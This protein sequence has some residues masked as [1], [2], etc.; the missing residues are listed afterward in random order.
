MLYNIIKY[1]LSNKSIIL[2]FTGLIVGFGIYALLNISIGAVPDVTNNQVQVITTSRDLS[3]EEVERY[4]TYPVELE[5][6]NLPGVQEIRSISKFGLSVVTIVFED[7][8]GTYLPRQLIGE[9]LKLIKEKIPEGFGTP[10]M[11]PI[12][13]G[14]GEIYQY[15]LDVR[16]GYED[17]YSVSDL[18]SIQDWIVRRQLSGIPGVVEINTWGGDLKTYEVAVNPQQLRNYK[19]SLSQVYE[20]LQ[21]N[22]GVV[23]GGYIEK[24]HEAFF[25]RADGLTKSIQDIENIVVAHKGNTPLYIN[26][27]G[28]VTFGKASRFGA[29]TGNGEGEKVL[30]QVMMLKG[31]N[32]KKVI[33][34]VKARV[35]KIQPSLPEGVYVNPFLERSD[36]INRTTTTIAENLILG[37][38]IV[39]IVVVFLLG[40]IRSGLVVASVIPLTLLFALSMMYLFGI[41]ANLMSLGAI[42]FGIIIDGAVIIVEYIAFQIT[43]NA[44][45]INALPLK[46][47]RGFIN[48]LTGE[49]AYKMMNSAIFGQVIIII[50]FIPILALTGVEGKMF[51]PMALTF[52]FALIGAMILCFTYVP[53]MASL[54]IRPNKN[55]RPNFSQRFITFLQGLYRLILLGALKLRAMVLT[56]AILMLIG[57]FWLLTLLGGEFV[58]TL[59]EGDFV[60]QPVLKTGMSLSE[61]VEMTTRIENILKR[62]PEVKQVVTRIGAAE[63][64]TDPMSME[65]SDIIITLQ[66]KRSWTIAGSKDELADEFKRALL[67]EIPGIEIEFTQ[68]IEMRF[69]EL[70]SGARSDLA[71]RLYGDDLDILY[72]KANEIESL[73]N[74]VPGAADISVEKIDGLPQMS[75]VYDRQKIAKYGVNVSQLNDIVAMGFAGKSAGLIF[76]GESS[77]DIVLRYDEPYRQSIEHLR[78]ALVDL[79]SG[80]QIALQEFATIDLRSGPAKISR[81]NTKR[82]VVVGVNVRGRDLKSVVDEIRVLIKDNITI[83]SGY[84]FHYGGQFEN[85]QKAQHRLMIVVP[86]AL[87]LIFIMLLFAFGSLRETLIIYSAIPLSAIGGILT[88]YLRGMPFSISAGVGFIALFG[89]AVLN[90]IVLIEH[91][92]EL[93]TEDMK[94]QT[95]TIVNGALDRLRPVL[96]TAMAAALGF[97]PMAISTSAGAEVQRP[98]ATVVIGGLISAT[99]LTLI[100]LP[101]LYSIFGQH[102]RKI[103]RPKTGTIGLILLIGSYGVLSGQQVLTV[104]EA[105]QI[106]IDRNT[107]TALAELD[108]ESATILVEAQ[109]KINPT[110]FY[111]G[112]DRNNTTDNGNAL[113][114]L[115]LSHSFKMPAIHNASKLLQE[116]KVNELSSEYDL[117]RYHLQGHIKL[118]YDKIQYLQAVK[119][120]YLQVD[121]L[122]QEYLVIVERKLKAGESSIIEKMT[123]SQK[124]NHT[125]LNAKNADFKIKKYYDQLKQALLSEEDIIIPNTEYQLLF[126][127]IDST[128]THPLI[129]LKKSTMSVQQRKNAVIQ[130]Q[131]SP[132]IKLSVFNGMNSFNQFELYP[133]IQVGISMPI[134]NKAFQLENKSAQIQDDISLQRIQSTTQHLNLL[135]SGYEEQL[136]QIKDQIEV[137]NSTIEPN[138]QELLETALRSLSAKEMNYLE[139]LLILDS[140]VQSKIQKWNLIHEY[141]QVQILSEYL[142]D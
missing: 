69:N 6:S 25:I 12:S 8:M 90:G 75:I 133:G 29:I 47:R 49:G 131:A 7:R 46:A 40:N 41:D 24:N 130:K 20:A 73:I 53:V 68:P 136:R 77:Y 142:I 37:F 103:T 11:G 100:I 120:V 38:I 102:H 62:F 78:E 96:L 22:N 26:D 132:E 85:L 81:N 36:L 80:Q 71:I 126:S 79:P 1:S 56:I 70:I 21:S 94:D 44:T 87:A 116:A 82:N 89:I 125:L 121:S 5:M 17:R 15:I 119:N 83:P 88:L 108:I 141:N 54:F 4:L 23:G 112:Y 13:T 107:L 105:Q 74:Q 18:R 118:I 64:P 31:A 19:I 45:K 34:A 27:I 99:L 127:I 91:F 50:V 42:D 138:S 128:G 61:T 97:L 32:S 117:Q 30:G 14:L 114:V 76:E 98:L 3:T 63:V 35:D 51:R 2:L 59:D 72:N 104:E 109:K 124:R 86:I 115:G 137:Y 43:R 113:H 140:T 10:F 93:K 122:Y 52:C 110:E 48:K 129:E 28:K 139:Y 66:P 33:D 55:S 57:S 84:Y 123:A 67:K 39:F 9:R 111:Y 101:I 58:P 134:S 60:I 16:P 106:A 65:E 135:R 95:K 92:K